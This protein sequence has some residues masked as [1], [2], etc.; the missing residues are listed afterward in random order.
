M[1]TQDKAGDKH[2]VDLAMTS[3]SYRMPPQLPELPPLLGWVLWWVRLFPGVVM[4]L[5]AW[6]LWI[7]PPTPTT[8]MLRW[9]SDT[10][11]IQPQPTAVF[12]FIFAGISLIW[13][14]QRDAL[15]KIPLLDTLGMFIFMF[16]L[17]TFAVLA[18]WYGFFIQPTT[19]KG[20]FMFYT[21]VIVTLL[22]LY[23]LGAW[24]RL[25][26]MQVRIAWHKVRTPNE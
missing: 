14:L 5:F 25:W 11:S 7:L 26:I 16:P 2:V 4:A 24:L 17:F 13:A 9:I 22:L 6:T 3:S 8:G 12:F 20:F 18:W 1:N 23:A 21:L 19:S 10:Y 15:R